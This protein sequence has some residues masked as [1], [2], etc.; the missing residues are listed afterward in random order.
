MLKRNTV[1]WRVIEHI[2]PKVCKKKNM[3]NECNVNESKVQSTSEKAML[4]IDI[5]NFFQVVIQKSFKVFIMIFSHY[6]AQQSKP[7]N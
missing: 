6:S 3:P 1:R 7:P 2:A 4:I 5:I